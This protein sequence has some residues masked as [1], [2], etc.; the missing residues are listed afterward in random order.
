MGLLMSDTVLI[1]PLLDETLRLRDGLGAWAYA[2]DLGRDRFEHEA[3]GPSEWEGPVSLHVPLPTNA[4][5]GRADDVA[6]HGRRPI[7]RSGPS[8]IVRRRRSPATPSYEAAR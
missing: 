3:P 8:L 2:L 4:A 6:G 1:D 5:M 7:G